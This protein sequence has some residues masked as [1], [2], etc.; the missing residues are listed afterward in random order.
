[1][2]HQIEDPQ[3]LRRKLPAFLDLP[4]APSLPQGQRQPAQGGHGRRDA[5]VLRDVPPA[6]AEGHGLDPLHFGAGDGDPLGKGLA[7][8]C[9]LSDQVQPAHERTSLADRAKRWLMLT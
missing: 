3:T 7:G 2:A 1:M 8:L 4:D 6:L 9:T 5:L